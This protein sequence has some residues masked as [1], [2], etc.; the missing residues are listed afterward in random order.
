MLKKLVSLAVSLGILALIYWKL[1]FHAILRT[2][3]RADLAWFALALVMFAP[4]ALLSSWR[5][6]FLA[7]RRAVPLGMSLRLFLASASLNLL[8]PSKMGDVIKVVFIRRRVAL[9]DGVLFSLAILEKALDMAALLLWCLLGVLLRPS[10]DPWV[11][12]LFACAA[13]GLTALGLMI[14]SPAAAAGLFG[15]AQRLLPARLAGKAAGLGASWAELLAYLSGIPRGRAVAVTVS[16]AIWLLHL[17]QIWLFMLSLHLGVDFFT[18]M[19]LTPLAIFVGLLPLTV[20]GVGTRDA[21]LIYFYA[22]YFPATAGAA[23][24]LL[25]TLRY[26]VPALAG[27]PFVFAFGKDL[28]LGK[29]MI[30][31][32]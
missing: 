24:G 6:S 15:L 5:F 26:L 22:T 2:L 18:N 8:L 19:A 20:A 10:D 3:A 25:C 13:T 11:W 7:P 1:D 9:S 31:R 27:V 21:A 16:L 30:H 17:F 12:V 14:L 32:T 28:K 23:L 29:E 4:T